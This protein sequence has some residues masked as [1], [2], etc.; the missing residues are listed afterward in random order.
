MEVQ[1]GYDAHP[2]QDQLSQT[3][4]RQFQ[5]AALAVVDLEE[6][7]AH[8]GVVDSS[9]CISEASPSIGCGLY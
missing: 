3:R 7:F 8:L 4:Y 9:Y 2:E 5:M 1:N 6:S